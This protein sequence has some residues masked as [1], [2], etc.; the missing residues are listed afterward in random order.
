MS[1]SSTSANSETT[2]THDLG[3]QAATS[4]LLHDRSAGLPLHAITTGLLKLTA[5]SL[6]V[7]EVMPPTI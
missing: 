3:H 7:L 4:S 1:E 2:D 6:A 5:T